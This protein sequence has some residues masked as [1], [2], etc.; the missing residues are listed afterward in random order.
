[1]SDVKYRP[2]TDRINIPVTTQT[3]PGDLGWVRVKKNAPY[4]IKHLKILRCVVSADQIG[5]AR[6]PIH[7]RM[8]APM[9]KEIVQ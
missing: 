4:P 3:S 8:V 7:Y 9:T 5:V 1:M 2:V 6:Q